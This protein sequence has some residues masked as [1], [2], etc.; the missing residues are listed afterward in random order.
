MTLRP[1]LASL[2]T[3]A[4]VINTGS[5]TALCQRLILNFCNC[6]PR[7]DNVVAQF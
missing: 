6:L 1:P 2:L 3:Q 5:M 4:S 7:I